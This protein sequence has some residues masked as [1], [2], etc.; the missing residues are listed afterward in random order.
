MNH[1]TTTVVSAKI[2]SQG[3]PKR[4]PLPMNSKGRSALNTVVSPPI[5]RATPR[6]AVSEPRVTMKGG[7]PR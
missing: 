4:L 1:D 2:A 3:T 7:S 5:S 6:T